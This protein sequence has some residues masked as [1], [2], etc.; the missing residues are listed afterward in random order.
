MIDVERYAPI[1]EKVVPID[2]QEYKLIVE[3]YKILV[4]GLPTTNAQAHS[5][6]STLDSLRPQLS[7]LIYMLTSEW[8]RLSS[9]HSLKYNK[10]YTRW[11]NSGTK[12]S[13]AAIEAQVYR[14]DVD[15]MKL[16]Y[17]MEDYNNLL[18]F[19]KSLV[20]SL[21]AMRQSVIQAWKDSTMYS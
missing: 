3:S 9:E 16:K 11:C 21:D 1:I 13:H 4:G 5:K 2:S 14:D 15:L 19:V 12:P 8:Y 10:D 6:L 7:S 20:K 18:E 17:K